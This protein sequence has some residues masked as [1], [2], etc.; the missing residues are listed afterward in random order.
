MA[1]IV[2]DVP[3]DLATH[4]DNKLGHKAATPVAQ[5]AFLEWAN[6]LLATSRPL[7]ISEMEIARVYI[8]YRNILLDELPSASQLSARLQ[9]PIAR[10]RYIVQSLGYQYPSLMHARLLSVL[11]SAYKAITI[12]GELY[13]MDVHPECDEVLVDLLSRIADSAHLADLR[14][15]RH[16]NVTRYE[17]TTGYYQRLGKAIDDELAA[18]GG[19]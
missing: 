12:N 1:R 16:G 13:V 3:D 17:L 2:I 5:A 4:L 19:A 9:L 10:C 11:Q 6:W 7:S 14:G 8:L 18:A 15:K